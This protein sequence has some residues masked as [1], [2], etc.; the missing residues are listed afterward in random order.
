VAQARCV[1]SRARDAAYERA[2]NAGMVYPW[3]LFAPYYP[4]LWTLSK[5]P[6]VTR[7]KDGGKWVC[8]APELEAA[9]AADE[10][11][12]CVAY[13]FGSRGDTYFES[14]LVEAAPSCEIHTFDKTTVAQPHSLATFWDPKATPEPDPVDRFW[15]H[16][17][18]LLPEDDAAVPGWTLATI[19]DGLGHRHVDILK[20]DVEGWEFRV[21]Q[22][23]FNGTRAPPRVGQILLEVHPERSFGPADIDDFFRLFEDLGFRLISLEPIG[24]N[25][26]PPHP[27]QKEQT[28]AEVVFVHRSWTP[29]G[30]ARARRGHPRQ[31]RDPRPADVRRSRARVRV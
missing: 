8:G 1:R 13:S 22:N 12:R 29:E 28:A 5:V 2:P 27:G 11:A 21:F 4:C 6:T 31:H 16:R 7:L 3:L 26:M 24:A 17:G 19:M 30:F 25:V 20:V 18:Y 14:A 23:I 9:R 10:A 15:F